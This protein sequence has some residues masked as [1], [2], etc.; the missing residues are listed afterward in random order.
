M[1]LIGAGLDVEVGNRSQA[2]AIL[3]AQR[4][5]LQSEIADGVHTGCIFGGVTGDVRASD[6]HPFD[7]NFVRKVRT[8]VD[9]AL[10]GTSNCPGQAV[11][12]EGLD[13]ALAAIA[14]VDRPGAEFLGRYRVPNL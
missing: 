7:Q 10:K 9:R 4:P 5:G 13:L 14:A 8:A 6:G 11:E 2:S 3:G 1:I 12:D